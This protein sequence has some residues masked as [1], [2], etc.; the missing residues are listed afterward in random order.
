MMVLALIVGGM[1][2]HFYFGETLD[3]HPKPSR[4][5]ALGVNGRMQF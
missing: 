2:L 4:M 5:P 1:L 3:E